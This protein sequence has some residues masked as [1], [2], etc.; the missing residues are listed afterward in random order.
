[1]YINCDIYIYYTYPDTDQTYTNI[2][3]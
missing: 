1:M 3:L 2:Y